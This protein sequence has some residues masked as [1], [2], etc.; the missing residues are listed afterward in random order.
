MSQEK[1]TL[2]DHSVLE[3]MFRL[4]ENGTNVRTEIIAGIT[5][6]ITMAYIIFVNPSILKEAGM[7]AAGLLGAE[8]AELGMVT[9]PVVGAVFVATCIAAVIGTLMMGIYA[10]LPFALAPGMG[11]NAF[12]AYSVV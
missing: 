7:N 11:L 10:N 5:T 4:K 8:A 6:F 2:Q 12:F 1:N 9:D 3:R